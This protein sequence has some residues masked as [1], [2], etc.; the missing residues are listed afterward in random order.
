VGENPPE[1]VKPRGVIHW[2]SATESID[3]EVRLYDRLF[4]DEAPDAGDKN[5]LDAIN[6]ESLTI[7]SG[8]KAENNLVSAV[9]EKSYQFEREGYFCLDSKFSTPEK[10]VFN[11][12]IGL[13]DNWANKG[14]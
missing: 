3:C 8:C 2:V 7:I 4:N 13:K 10:P 12:T 9:A 14:K 6:P 1:G 5:F 11:R